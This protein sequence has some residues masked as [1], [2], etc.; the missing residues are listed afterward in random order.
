LV[1]TKVSIGAKYLPQ[2]M[3]ILI[4]LVTTSC[5]CED[6]ASFNRLMQFAHTAY[7]NPQSVFKRYITHDVLEFLL[8]SQSKTKITNMKSVLQTA[9][10]LMLFLPADAH[11]C[12]EL[13]S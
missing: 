7:L 4:I 3:S 8:V 11:F 6:F 13:L 9:R 1:E 10:V 5:K 2:F 12:I